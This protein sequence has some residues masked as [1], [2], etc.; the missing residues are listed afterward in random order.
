MNNYEMVHNKMVIIYIELGKLVKLDSI[1][2][3]KWSLLEKLSYILKYS[4]DENRYDIINLLKEEEEVVAMMCDKKTEYF[5]TTTFDIAKARAAFDKEIEDHLEELAYE[6]G[7]EDGFEDGILKIVS[8][9]KS[10][11]MSI[12]EISNVT[13]LSIE[14]VTKVLGE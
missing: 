6:D 13:N 4:Q 1:P 14:E 11:G 12:D 9:M 8:F 7:F 2:I 10:N 3:T 5:R